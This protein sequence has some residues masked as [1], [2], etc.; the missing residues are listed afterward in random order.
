ML[1]YKSPAS[2]RAEPR[3][4]LVR[5]ARAAEFFD[6]RGLIEML[7]DR[8]R[9]GV[10]YGGV[11]YVALLNDDVQQQLRLKRNA[12]HATAFIGQN[13]RQQ[14]LQLGEKLDLLPLTKPF[15]GNGLRT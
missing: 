15:H 6:V 13:Q 11:Q 2:G 4:A 9:G 5:P 10:R 7:V 12:L 14:L 8:V 3:L 1:V